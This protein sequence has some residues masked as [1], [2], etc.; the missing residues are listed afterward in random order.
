MF[1]SFEKVDCFLCA[2][3]AVDFLF[4]TFLLHLFRHV[5]KQQIFR[6]EESIGCIV[7]DNIGPIHHQHTKF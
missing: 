3:V 4:F 1:S 2:L 7:Q 6:S 5:K